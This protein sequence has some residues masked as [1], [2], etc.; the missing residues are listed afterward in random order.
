MIYNLYSIK[1]YPSLNSHYPLGPQPRDS[2]RKPVCLCVLP[3]PL[4][5]ILNSKDRS[6]DRPG[7]PS[8]F[9]RLRASCQAYIGR[10]FRYLRR[11]DKDRPVRLPIPRAGNFHEFSWPV[12]DPREADLIIL[13]TSHIHAQTSPST[14][15]PLSSHIFIF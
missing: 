4:Y 8:I 12:R 2:H 1:S 10:N 9:C 7:I 3:L 14:N 5:A 11:Q 13:L 15:P 6:Y